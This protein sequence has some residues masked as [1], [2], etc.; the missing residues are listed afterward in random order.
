M[1]GKPKNRIGERYG[2]LVVERISERRTPS[3]AAYWLC[4]CDCGNLREVAGD[5]LFHN[6]RKTRKSVY[7]CLDCVNKE[8]IRFITERN[9]QAEIERRVKRKKDREE[10]RG[11]VPDE[12]F[13]LAVTEQEARELNQPSY[14]SGIKCTRGHIETRR[15]DGTCRECE[16]IRQANFRATPEGKKYTSEESKKRWADPEKRKQ[17]QKQRRE[18]AQTEEGKAKLNEI[19]RRF[20]WNNRESQRQKTTAREKIR[21]KTDPAF[22]LRSLL[23]R[24]ILLALKE[25]NSTKDE[26]TMKLV[27]CSMKNLLEH[28]ESLFS[29]NMAWDNHGDWHI[30]HIRPCSSFDLLD[31]EQ[32]KLCF[33]WRNLQPL[34]AYENTTIKRDNYNKKDESTWEK[35]MRDLGY[36]GELFLK[37]TD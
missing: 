15:I 35:R 34:E 11:I 4:R 17:R 20:Y 16:R 6:K 19:W 21:R 14:F 29:E 33:N 23:Q 5:V 13:A 26:T 7:A 36:E 9:E 24:R 3:G 18:Y 31:I 1:S 30:D 27:G 8:Q 2:R 28:F 22:K 12:W 10:Y 32:Q 25:Q 37:Y